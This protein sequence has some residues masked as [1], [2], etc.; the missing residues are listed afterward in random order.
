MQRGCSS[1]VERNLAKVDVVGSN[2]IARSIPH[3]GFPLLLLFGSCPAQLMNSLVRDVLCE[4]LRI[5]FEVVFYGICDF[6]KFLY[7]RLT[8]K[9]TVSGTGINRKNRRRQPRRWRR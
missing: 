7:R 6:I 2:P 9:Q 3:G 5:V 4:V 1:V 8:G